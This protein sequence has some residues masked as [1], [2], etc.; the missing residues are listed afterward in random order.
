MKLLKRA[1]LLT[2]CL[3]VCLSVISVASFK[4]DCQPLFLHSLKKSLSRLLS[5]YTIV[6][7]SVYKIF[8]SSNILH[9]YPF[10]QKKRPYFRSLSSSSSLGG[11]ASISISANSSGFSL[12]PPVAQ[13]TVIVIDP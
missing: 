10:I 13:S 9:E 5:L 7:N 2:V 6:S 12:Y 8:L 4:H 1:D 3:S 11:N